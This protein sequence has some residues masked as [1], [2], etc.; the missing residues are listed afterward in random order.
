MPNYYYNG[1]DAFR[2]DAD[3]IRVPV[4]S[5]TFDVDLV[6]GGSLG[7]RT[8]DAFGYVAAGFFTSGSVG[9]EIEFSHA[10][11]PGTFRRTLAATAA[12]AETAP[13]NYIP[14][15]LVENLATAREP[16]AYDIWVRDLDKTSAVDVKAGTVAANTA[17]KLPLLNI[18]DTNFRVFAHPILGKTGE[19]SVL[20][21]YE[22]PYQD[23][24]AAG[25]PGSADVPPNYVYAG[26]PTA[27]DDV[28]T[29]RT[30]VAA[31]I[32]SIDAA[33]ITSG[34]LPIAR[35][36]T[37]AG[38]FAVSNGV[39]YFNGT[40]LVNDADLGFDGS[41][42][43]VGDAPFT[44]RLNVKGGIRF[45]SS[46][47]D[48]VYVTMEA[49]TDGA[50]TL[51][52][53]TSPYIGQSLIKQPRVIGPT[54]GSTNQFI[55]LD[56]TGIKYES[57]SPGWGSAPNYAAHY[58]N[59]N[60]AV[61]DADQRLARFDNNGTEKS[62]FSK[63]GYLGIGLGAANAAAAIHAIR[64]SDV[65]RVGYDASNYMKADVSSTG[66]VTFDAVGSG[67]KFLFSDKVDFT[68]DVTF[69]DAKNIIVGTTTGTK[70]GTSSSQKLG[71]FGATPVTQRSNVGTVTIGSIAGGDTVD[72]GAV[73]D[74]LTDIAS[75][76]SN[77][78]Q[79]FQD[80]GL[81]N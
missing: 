56:G 67:V 4:V 14:A 65:L 74:A 73:A 58:F 70:I 1:F 55:Q 2:I 61:T 31:D 35:G 41:K 72:S 11:Y 53:F 12:D 63:D 9:A 20:R 23:I 80:L 77:I 78:E 5:A 48:Y 60:T 25:R 47:Y 15:Y 37:N 24:G 50:N 34:T 36:G 66:V 13:D 76:L 71:F 54:Y 69:T 18:V 75:I 46:S 59:T 62:F 44:E 49:V 64:T 38:T 52:G 21:Y 51:I 30:L 10:T 32:P 6:G 28:P 33:K 68:D 26:P 29:F 17:A 3:G 8:S 22:S 45:S 81:T 43:S 16:V 42:L 40:A 79:V 19:T 7:T 39:V 57:Y 27:P